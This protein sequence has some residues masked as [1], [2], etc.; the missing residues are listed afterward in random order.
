MLPAVFASLKSDGLATYFTR[1]NQVTPVR[2]WQLVLLCSGL[3]FAAVLASTRLAHGQAGPTGNPAV[4]NGAVSTPRGLPDFADLVEKTSPAVVNIRTSVKQKTVSNDEEGANDPV[5]ELF[6]RFFGPGFNLPQ[7]PNPRPRS[8]PRQAPRDGEQVI[9]RGN[10]T[11]FIIASDGVILTNHHVVEGADEITVTLTDKREFKAKLIGSDER[12]D[13]AVLKVETKS[14][15]TLS[16]GDPAKNR[17]GEWVVAIGSPFGLENTVTAGII[18]AKSRDTGGY[19]PFIQTDVAVNPGNSGGP[20]INMRGEV[21]GINSQ[22]ISRSG[23]FMGISLSIPIDEA[24]RIADQIR[25]TGKV[26]RGRIGVQIE[27][28]TKEMAEGLGLSKSQ[29]AFVARVEP[30]SPAE[31]AGIQN[32]DVILKFADKSIEKSSDLPRLVGALP[33]GSKA[34]LEVWRKGKAKELTIQIG[35]SEPAKVAQASKPEKAVSASNPLGIRA[36]ELTAEQ[37]RDLRLREGGVLID[38]VEDPATQV[39]LRKGDVLLRIDNNDINNL[40]DFEQQLNRLDGKRAVGL[41]VM[42]G[43]LVQFVRIRPLVK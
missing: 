22:I 15:P 6:R 20:L 5:E 28:V 8:N 37:R 2:L 4:Q 32:G 29:G 27:P 10:G 21:I 12:T 38:A 9:P 33:P 7:Q 18:S 3:L 1:L 30:N 35:D 13:V 42:R 19:L 34:K 39:G 16:I 43:D 40:A 14:L 11:G 23:G 36:T 26:T 24:M 31:K 17:V 41:L 25:T